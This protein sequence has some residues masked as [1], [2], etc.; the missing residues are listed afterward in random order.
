[1]THNN[2]VLIAFALQ[3][4]WLDVNEG[5][6]NVAQTLASI[7]KKTGCTSTLILH[8]LGDIMSILW[9]ESPNP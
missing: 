7:S 1:M 6:V 3:G 4:N 5:Y 8:N 9:S 2:Q